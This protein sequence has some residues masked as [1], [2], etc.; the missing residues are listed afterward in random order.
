MKINTRELIIV[1]ARAITKFADPDVLGVKIALQDLRRKRTNTLSMQ[2]LIMMLK[3]VYSWQIYAP[4]KVA[5][6]INGS[7]TEETFLVL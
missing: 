5:S 7:N 6:D 1:K 4:S 3:I 2:M